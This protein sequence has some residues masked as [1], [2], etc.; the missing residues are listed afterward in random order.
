VQIKKAGFSVVFL[1]LVMFTYPTFFQA[2]IGKSR[3]CG[4]STFDASKRKKPNEDFNLHH[5]CSHHVNIMQL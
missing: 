3:A 4:Q 1:F 5:H 2:V